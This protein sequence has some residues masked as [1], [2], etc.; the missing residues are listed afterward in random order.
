MAASAASDVLSQNVGDA[1]VDG[2][3][4]AGFRQQ[5]ELLQGGEARDRIQRRARA[6][7]EYRVQHLGRGAGLFQQQ[8]AQPFRR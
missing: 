4:N 2:G 8:A 6:V 5:Q 1:L 7:G 3:E